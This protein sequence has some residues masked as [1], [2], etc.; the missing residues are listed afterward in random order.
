MKKLL[1]ILSL[2]LLFFSCNNNDDMGDQTKE[3][4]KIYKAS[5]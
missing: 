3:E 1:I 2:A 4:P 5:Y